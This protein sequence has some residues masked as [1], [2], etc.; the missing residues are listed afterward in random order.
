MKKFRSWIEIWLNGGT[1]RGVYVAPA[2]I[3]EC[4]RIFNAICRKEKPTFIMKN[5][6]DILDRCDIPT[7]ENGIGWKVV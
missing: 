7:V 3:H 6:K 2:D 1:V 4:I 5:V